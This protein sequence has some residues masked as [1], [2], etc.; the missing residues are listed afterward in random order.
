MNSWTTITAGMP[1]NGDSGVK[2]DSE[3]KGVW[4]K[5]RG[6]RVVVKA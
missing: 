6:K 3:V 4:G 5:E 1:C 2:R